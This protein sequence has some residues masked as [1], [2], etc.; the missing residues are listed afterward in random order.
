MTASP[1]KVHTSTRLSDV[2]NILL[3]STFTGVPVVDEKDRPVGVI[4]QGDLIYKAKMPLRLGP[5]IGKD[6][7]KTDEILNA[8]GD[9]IAGDIMSK[10]AI[11]IEQSQPATAAVDLML[12]K[13]VKRLPVVNASGNLVGI[14][15]RLDIFQTI[16]RECPDWRAFQ[17]KSI[18]VK[19]L[20]YV[21]DITRSD[22]CT[23]LPDTPV[24]E[25]IQVIDRNDIER[26]CVVDKEG[27]FLGMISDRNLLIAFVDRHPG[28]WDYLTSKIPFTEKGRR[29]REL[30]EHLQAKT[31]AE[32]MKTQVLTIREDAPL[33]DAIRLMLERVIKRLPV[34]DKDGRFKGIISRDSLLRAGFTSF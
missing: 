7:S 33:E 11:I 27:L 32:V 21:S 23:V 25:V 10:P 4:A 30:Q 17:D 8:L 2:A 12:E 28:I 5:L 31:A 1:E 26:V 24:D 29:H 22:I 15:S 19:N 18:D 34:V 14:V 16:V 6:P 13:H 9:K 20:K 3:S